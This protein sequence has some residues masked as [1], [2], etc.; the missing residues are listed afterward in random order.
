MKPYFDHEGLRVYQ[1]AR[2]FN[3]EV[4]DILKEI[5]RGHADS[6]NQLKRSSKSVTKNIAEGSGKWMLKDKIHYFHIAR[7]SATEAAATLDELVDYGLVPEARI[8]HAKEL[9]AQVVA[10]LIGMIRSLEGR[11]GVDMS[12]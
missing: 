12:G 2:A 8:R 4:A 1:V 6:R 3:R 11:E 10:M 9:V 5:P 7:G